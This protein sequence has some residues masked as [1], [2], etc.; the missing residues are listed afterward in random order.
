MPGRRAAIIPEPRNKTHKRAGR[1]APA[2]G[3][4]GVNHRV[5]NLSAL[6]RRE[7]HYRDELKL[8]KAQSDR[9]FEWVPPIG[10]EPTLRTLLGGCLFHWATGAKCCQFALTMLYQ[11]DGPYKRMAFRQRGPLKRV[12]VLHRLGTKRNCGA[13]CGRA[14]F[15]RLHRGIGQ[16]R[17]LPV[18]RPVG[19][20]PRE[21]LITVGNCLPIAC[22]S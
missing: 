16:H 11:S 22:S 3:G 1:T 5:R 21:E 7:V 2:R 10:F 20:A 18:D 6:P 15:A 4:V 14:R 8:M 13:T 9:N 19:H 12:T 17:P